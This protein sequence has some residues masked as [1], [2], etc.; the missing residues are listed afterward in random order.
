MC[1]G[2]HFYSV[3]SDK[4]KF[5]DNFFQA[6]ASNDY[7]PNSDRDGSEQWRIGITSLFADAVGLAPF[8]DTF[9]TTT[10]QTGNYYKGQSTSTCFI[11]DGGSPFGASDVAGLPVLD[12][13]WTDL[14]YTRF[15]SFF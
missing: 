15:H 3:S 10:N 6:R 11:C 13:G 1:S 8:K 9:W 12:F 5:F 14:S 7:Q 4:R 2:S